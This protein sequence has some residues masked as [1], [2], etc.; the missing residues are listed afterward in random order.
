MIKHKGELQTQIDSFGHNG[1]S[2]QLGRCDCKNCNP[3]PEKKEGSTP[4]NYR[5]LL[6]AHFGNERSFWLFLLGLVVFLIF[7]FPIFLFLVYIF[8]W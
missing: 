2:A 5:S 1:Y 8:N 4:L 3:A 7:T 6:S